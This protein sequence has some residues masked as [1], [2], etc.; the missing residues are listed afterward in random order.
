MPNQ[1]PAVDSL[2][3]CKSVTSDG[4]APNEYPGL[5]AGDDVLYPGCPD[6]GAAYGDGT[7]CLFDGV[8]VCV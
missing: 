4:D 7:G 3:A 6:P 8:C 5:P 2:F 1:C